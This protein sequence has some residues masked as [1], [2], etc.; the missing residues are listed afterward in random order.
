MFSTEPKLDKQQ[1]EGPYDNKSY[2]VLDKNA[3][4]WGWLNDDVSVP[5]RQLS[6]KSCKHSYALHSRS[7]RSISDRG[8]TL[9]RSPRPELLRT[10]RSPCQH[11]PYI[12]T[13]FLSHTQKCGGVIILDCF[14]RVLTPIPNKPTTKPGAGTPQRRTPR[15]APAAHGCASRS[16]S[17]VRGVP[18]PGGEA[19][20]GGSQ[21]QSLT[22]TGSHSWR[23]HG[24]SGGGVVGPKLARSRLASLPSSFQE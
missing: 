22:A 23:R 6:Y 10:N 20:P 11:A 5:Y 21:C 2:E 16:S 4:W 1:Q 8:L 17:S 7:L 24:R 3:H 19:T 15:E 13:H 14:T 12:R 18:V 9:Y